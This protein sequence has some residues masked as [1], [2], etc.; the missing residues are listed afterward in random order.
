MPVDG[1][2]AKCASA[3]GRSREAALLPRL[4]QL[5]LD[6]LH[7]RLTRD[8]A[9]AEGGV[10]G[11]EVGVAHRGGDGRERGRVLQLLHRETAPAKRPGQLLAAG[12]DG[13][14]SALGQNHCLILLRARERWRSAASHAT[15]R[16][17]RLGGDDLHC[18]ARVELGVE[19]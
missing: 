5:P 7:E 2:G 18:V 11:I 16:P 4:P 19:G 13:V 14:F 8:V 15:G 12:L 10:Q 1:A 9:L 17:R 3:G 6:A